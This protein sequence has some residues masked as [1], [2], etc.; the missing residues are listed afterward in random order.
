MLII[1]IR[2]I[3]LYL[4]VLVIFRIMGKRQIGE[5]QPFELA[6]TIMISALAAFPM[7]DTR[8]PLVNTLI[9]MIM[10]LCLHIY[11]SFITLKST[12]A[13]RIICGK[14]TTLIENGTIN[15]IELKKHR[16]NIDE[17]VEEL[18]LK[19]YS[20]ISDVEFAFIE[21][22]GQVSVIPKS[23]KR[24]VTPADLQIPTEYEGVSHSLIVDG[25]VYYQNLKKIGLTTD[26]LKTEL[27]KLGISNFS[28]VLYA[29]IDS[30]GKIYYQKTQKIQAR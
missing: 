12:P 22:N 29:S 27:R 11:I 30:A 20:N 14:P 17:L 3:F 26:W 19:G 16:I 13:R 9:P 2:T 23:Q 10:L 21:T 28:D 7:E 25:K 24:P 1:A 5:L 6:I 15:E 4:T 8:L 18:R